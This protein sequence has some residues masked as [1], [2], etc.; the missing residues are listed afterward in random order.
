MTRAQHK[1]DFFAKAQIGRWAVSGLRQLAQRTDRL[2]EF[3]CSGGERGRVGG[4]WVE[5]LS[6]PSL[7]S[8]DS[9]IAKEKPGASQKIAALCTGAIPVRRA[10]LGF[11]LIE[12]LV[13]M[14]IIG[15]LAA[16]TIPALKGFGQSNT[17]AAANRQLLD[18]LAYAR[19]SALNNRTDVYFLFPDPDY[20][21]KPEFMSNLTRKQLPVGTNLLAGVYSSYGVYAKRRAGEQPGREN[22]WYLMEWKTLPDGVFFATNKFNPDVSPE[23]LDPDPYQAPFASMDRELI[24]FPTAEGKPSKFA[25]KGFAFNSRGQLKHGKEVVI[26]LMRGSI[27][28]VRDADGNYMPGEPD[29]QETPPGGSI[30]NFNRIVIDAMTG[31]ARVERPEIE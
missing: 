22:P 29:V 21:T 3:L 2:H 1:N 17:M 12:L 16:I 13:V 19:A 24:R 5:M 9:F 15:L 30:D 11:T 14:V 10:V 23:N 27:F 31:R 20:V 18:D 8:C 28:P 25:V 26:P 7:E 4:N 6:S